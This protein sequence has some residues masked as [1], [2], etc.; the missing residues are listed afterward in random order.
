L[1]K[2]KPTVAIQISQ[3]KGL[4]YIFKIRTSY[5]KTCMGI[6]IARFSLWINWISE[7]SKKTDCRLSIQWIKWITD[8]FFWKIHLGEL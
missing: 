3:N 4:E 8:S 2:A 7:S 1:Q 5:S 6:W